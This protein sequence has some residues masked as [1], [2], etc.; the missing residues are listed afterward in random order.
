MQI[1]MFELFAGEVAFQG[2]NLG[3]L[4]FQIGG[5]PGRALAMSPLR[6]LHSC[7]SVTCLASSLCWAPGGLPGFMLCGAVH[8]R[9]RPPIPADCPADYTELM[10]RCWQNDAALRPTFKDVL[11]SL[12]AQFS[13]LRAGRPKRGS[14]T[15]GLSA[16]P[17]ASPAPSPVAS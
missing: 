12:Q 1:I 4:I 11:A 13:V 14:G 5:A 15:P 17:A 6:S 10:Q 2:A 7:V 16:A 9:E 8:K 3:H